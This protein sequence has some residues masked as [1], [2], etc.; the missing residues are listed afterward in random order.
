MD[1]DIAAKL[2]TGMNSNIVDAYRDK[3]SRNLQAF[4]KIVRKT[5]SGPSSVELLSLRML[6]PKL[7]GLMA[8]QTKM[9]GTVYSTGE[10]FIEMLSWWE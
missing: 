3:G 9:I 4:I 2:M 10:E 1:L 7:S 5:G 8:H 6:P